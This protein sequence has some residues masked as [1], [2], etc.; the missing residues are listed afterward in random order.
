MHNIYHLWLRYNLKYLNLKY[1]CKLNIKNVK[2]ELIYLHMWVAHV[3]HNLYKRTFT[4]APCTF[5][6]I[7][8][9]NCQKSWVSKKE[10]C[11]SITTSL[12]LLSSSTSREWPFKMTACWRPIEHSLIIKGSLELDN[13]D[14]SILLKK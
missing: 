14:T 11:Q 10:R 1:N 13:L 2:F 3:T 6:I 4:L 5:K 12:M 9:L 7:N 8:F